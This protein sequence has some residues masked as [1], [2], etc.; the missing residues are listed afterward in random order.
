[1]KL[2]SIFEQKNY[3][4]K[5]KSVKKKLTVNRLIS[6]EFIPVDIDKIWEIDIDNNFNKS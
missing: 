1:M 4:K 6:E 3:I 2:K 5:I